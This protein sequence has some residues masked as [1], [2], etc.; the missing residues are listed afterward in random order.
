MGKKVILTLEKFVHRVLTNTYRNL[1]TTLHM[2]KQHVRYIFSNQQQQLQEQ[3]LEQEKTLA[4]AS[5]APYVSNKIWKDK[6]WESADLE[7]RSYQTQLFRLE[8]VASAQVHRFQMALKDQEQCFFKEILQY[9]EEQL[10]VIDQL[11]EIVLETIA[12]IQ[13]VTDTTKEVIQLQFSSTDNE[14]KYT[15]NGSRHMIPNVDRVECHSALKVSSY[16]K[17]WVSS[18]IQLR[19]DIAWDLWIYLRGKQ[20][21]RFC[22]EISNC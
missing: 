1:S 12:I 5:A 4:K 16:G 9:T 2:Y 8:S 21:G 7:Q 3:F 13:H 22:G 11:Q 15:T 18:L 19:F 10:Q 17:R 20:Q 6:V 14:R